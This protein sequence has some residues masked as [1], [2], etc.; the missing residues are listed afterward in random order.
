MPLKIFGFLGATFS[1]PNSLPRAPSLISPIVLG[2]TGCHPA[3]PGATQDLDRV[4]G[5][6]TLRSRGAIRNTLGLIATL[7]VLSITLV[8]SSLVTL[9][10]RS[11]TLARL[12]TL[13][14][15]RGPIANTRGAMRH[16]RELV[17][18]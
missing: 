16:A 9:V 11:V 6:A 2:V 4:G 14:N 3:S 5:S 10:V 13:R 8:A 12:L 1:N 15:T 18:C 7:A 17:D